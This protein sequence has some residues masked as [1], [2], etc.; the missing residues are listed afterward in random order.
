MRGPTATRVNCP[1]CKET[2]HWLIPSSTK[3]EDAHTLWSCGLEVG[4]AGYGAFAYHY[5]IPCKR[6]YTTRDCKYRRQVGLNQITPFSG[7][8]Y[9]YTHTDLLALIH[10]IDN[11]DFDSPADEL[12]HRVD[13]HYFLYMNQSILGYELNM[14]AFE[15]KLVHS[16]SGRPFRPIIPIEENVLIFNCEKMIPLLQDKDTD[17]DRFLLADIYRTMRQFEK[18]KNIL[19]KITSSPWRV[20]AMNKACDAQENGKLIVRQ[21]DNET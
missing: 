2:G 3:K 6:I 20:L 18:A 8:K 14:K 19:A 10:F 11:Y 21:T 4:G 12:L 15:P 7:K 17:A 9:D 16:G 13:L 1:D 5:C